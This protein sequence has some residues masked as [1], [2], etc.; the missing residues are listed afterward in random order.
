[1]LIS[2]LLSCMLTGFAQELVTFRLQKSGDFV[3]ADGA[4]FA[5]VE[6]QGKSVAELYQMI[7][8]NVGAYYENPDDVLTEDEP[9]SLTV[10]GGCKDFVMWTFMMMP[11]QFGA[12]YDLT[13]RFREGRIRVDA[14]VIDDELLTTGSVVKLGKTASF[15]TLVGTFYKKGELKE[16]AKP[17]VAQIE[18]YLNTTINQ[19]LGL[20]KEKSPDEEEW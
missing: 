2:A 7:K 4:D 18:N 13:F 16:K 9:K 17:K 10:R 20:L 3:T 8:D 14:P 12:F 19:L 6:F 15:R 11:T 5:V 1:M